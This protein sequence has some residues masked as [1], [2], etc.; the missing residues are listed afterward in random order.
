MNQ[1]LEKSKEKRPRRTQDSSVIPLIS[2]QQ[3]ASRSAMLL[4]LVI[5]WSPVMRPSNKVHLHPNSSA[6]VLAVGAKSG[7]VSFWKVNV[8]ECYSLA[9]CMVPSRA[10][11]VGLLQAHNSWI[12]CISWMLFDSDSSKPKVLLATGSTD[13]R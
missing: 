10:L 8:P 13:G 12:N 1:P 2:A 7:K 5:A 3:Y 4:S 9:E 6:S 11:L